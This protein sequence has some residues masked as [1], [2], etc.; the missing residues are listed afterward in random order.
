MFWSENNE[1]YKL[2]NCKCVR[3]S[4]IYETITTTTTINVVTGILV[5]MYIFCLNK[6]YIIK[7]EAVLLTLCI[8]TTGNYSVNT[9]FRLMRRILELPS[10]I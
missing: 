4:E 8:P 6:S 10:L 2:E 9:V 7:V 3:N 5:D 1:G